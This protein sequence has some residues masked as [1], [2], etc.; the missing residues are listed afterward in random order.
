MLMVSAALSPHPTAQVNQSSRKRAGKSCRCVHRETFPRTK[1]TEKLGDETWRRALSRS[2]AWVKLQSELYSKYL[3]FKFT[4]VAKNFAAIWYSHKRWNSNSAFYHN[5]SI[6]QSR[7]NQ[8]KIIIIQFTI[9]SNRRRQICWTFFNHIFVKIS[10]NH[11][12]I[13]Q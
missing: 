2:G 1:F 8:F 11:I 10:I 5:P 7:M 4:V 6:K 3:T 9:P 12:I 13:S